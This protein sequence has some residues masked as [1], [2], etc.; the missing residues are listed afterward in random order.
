MTAM[1]TF[2]ALPLALLA[3]SGAARPAA[4]APTRTHARAA[5]RA[6]TRADSISGR[7]TETGGAAVAGADVSLPELLRQTRTR[8]DGTFAFAD[9][10][11]GEYTVVVRRA[12]YAAESRRVTLPG[13]GT[14][15]VALRATPFPLEPVTVTAT[16]TPLAA[17]NTP[18]ASAALDRER[19]RRA[20]GVSLAQTI[21][22]VPGVRTL[23][24]GEQIGKPVIRGLSGSRVLVMDG[25]HRVEDYS[26]SDEDGP[27]VDPRLAERIE[28]IR[29]PASLMYGSDALGGVVNSVPE[30]VPDARLGESFARTGLEL[31]GTT[32]GAGFGG[33]LRGEGARGG[34]GWRATGIGRFAEDFSSPRAKLEN[35]G[36][37]ALNGEAAAGL[38]GGW[39]SATLRYARYGGEFRLLEANGPPPAAAVASG[40]RAAVAGAARMEEEGPVRKLAD[41][42]VQLDAALPFSGMRL[43]AKAQ[44]QRHW[45][46]E[47][48]DEGGGGPGQELP[49][50][51]LTLN[52]V[53]AD[54]VAHHRPAGA[55]RGALGLSGVLQSNGVGGPVLLVPDARIA[56]G[57]AFLVEQGTWG[58][59]SLLG[60]AR[61]DARSL[62]A[63]ALPALGLAQDQD[64]SWTA[65]SGDVGIV[66]RPVETVALRAN[67]GRAW[68]APNLFELFANGPRIGDARYEI[69]DASLDVEKSL[70]LDG[71][72]RWRAGAVSGEVSAYRNHISDFIFVQPTTESRQGLQVFR[73]AQTDATLS[74]LD[75]VAEADVL[76]WLGLRA[77]GG[78]VR[79][80]DETTD[81]PLPLMPPPR[82]SFA[83]EGHTAGL[84]GFD[85][86]WASAEVERV[87]RASRVAQAETPLP[88]YTLLH[89]GAGLAGRLRGRDVRFDLQV[90]NATNTTYKDFLSRYKGF[91]FNPGRSLTLRLSTGS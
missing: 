78:F 81:Q 84:A 12:G 59:F 79:G 26:W 32:N 8:A 31:Y 34:L 75:G 69:G 11:A 66:F 39:G 4:G 55:V 70:D 48:S 30:E 24:T 57:G 29:G 82:F 46:E 18:L 62:R 1:T 63:D 83:A 3:A 14:V 10:P 33:V 72:V 9:V 56:S 60:G 61:V 64:R 35:T 49:A 53:S 27:S 73:Y 89:L 40:A 68:R 25:G 86:A 52:T 44:W 22:Q 7:V 65:A 54:V 20:H 88:G 45:L 91:A 90:R 77:G 50:F 19:L 6:Q 42:R 85:R 38:R 43:E 5:A 67:I 51:A 28:V 41:D 2:L 36:Y 58:A 87:T 74:G 80:T 16:R 13:G 15:D 21:E 23:S 17:S 76:P 37:F 47:V 71:G